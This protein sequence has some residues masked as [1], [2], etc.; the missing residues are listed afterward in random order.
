VCKACW[1]R[2]NTFIPL[3]VYLVSAPILYFVIG[4]GSFVTT[5]WTE[6]AYAGGALFIAFWPMILIV[7]LMSPDARFRKNAVAER[8]ESNPSAEFKLYTE[9]EYEKLQ[10]KQ[11]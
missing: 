10:K 11:T 5:F 9:R 2:W 8:K 4:G 7:G 1:K 6:M 3:I